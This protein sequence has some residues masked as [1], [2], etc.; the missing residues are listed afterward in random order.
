MIRTI[1]DKPWLC[2]AMPIQVI[3]TI[4]DKIASD[5]G[6]VECLMDIG[7]IEHTKLERL[8]AKGSNLSLAYMP[9]RLP[10][11]LLS[12]TAPQGFYTPI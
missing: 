3:R 7:L 8:N 11:V 1:V 4:V 12:K 6:T 9:A 10:R 2:R 5:T